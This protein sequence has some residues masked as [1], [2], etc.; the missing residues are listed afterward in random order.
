[1]KPV[2]PGGGDTQNETAEVLICRYTDPER[3]PADFLGMDFKALFPQEVTHL[4]HLRKRLSVA[5]QVLNGLVV[6]R[7]FFQN[8]PCPSL[9][10]QCFSWKPWL[11][12]CAVLWERECG[13]TDDIL[14]DHV[15]LIWAWPCQESQCIMG[16]AK[17]SLVQTREIAT[18]SSAHVH[19][20]TV[21]A[22][23]IYHSFSLPEVYSLRLPH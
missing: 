21:C 15:L 2:Y 3:K 11:W 20:L 16:M 5:G 14:R 10:C 12:L 23:S 18:P 4:F 1:M 22:E 7:C 6:R 13:E 8:A 17:P 9:L 19:M